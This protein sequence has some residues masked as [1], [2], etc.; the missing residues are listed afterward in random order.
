M[1]KHDITEKVVDDENDCVNYGWDKFSFEWAYEHDYV[2]WE[3]KHMKV[4]ST[5][6]FSE[7]WAWKIELQ[8]NLIFLMCD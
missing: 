8:L 4:G 3:L 7:I 6:T 5:I 2:D 1:M